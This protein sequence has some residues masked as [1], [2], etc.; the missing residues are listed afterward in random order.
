MRHSWKEIKNSEGYYSSAECSNCKKISTKENYNEDCPGSIQKDTA[1]KYDSG[2]D[3]LSWSLMPY[4]GVEGL[5]RVMEYGKRKYTVCG[6]C[7]ARVYKIETNKSGEI[8]LNEARLLDK[9]GAPTKTECPDC[10]SKNIVTGCHNWRKGFAW[11]RLIDSA[12]RHLTSILKGE[13][14]DFESL[15]PHAFHLTFCAA[16]LAEHY[17]RQLGTDDRF[18]Y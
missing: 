3:K 13:D 8:V 14:V 10:E 2:G 6:D 1:L 16:T 18:K 17:T 12:Y 7:G 15:E 4:D 5:L 11:T 9:G